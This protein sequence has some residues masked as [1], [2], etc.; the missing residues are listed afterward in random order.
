MDSNDVLDDKDSG[1]EVQLNFPASVMSRIEE[2]MGG[3]E[4]FDM[5]YINRVFPT[6]Q[7]LSAVEA[8]AAR[9]EFRLAAVQHDMQRLVRAQHDQRVADINK[10][11]SRSESMVREITSEIK[12]LDCAKWNL[13]S[14]ITA[15][16]HLHML[17]GGAATLRSL[18]QNRQY[19]ELVLPLQAIMEVLQHL[20]CYRDIRELN[21]LRE[22]VRVIRSQ[23]ADQIVADFKQAFTGECHSLYHTI[24]EYEH[25]FS[26]EQ[27]SAWLAHIERRY[28]WLKKHLLSFEETLGAVFP[29]HWRLSERIAYQFCK[30][31]RDMLSE[32]LVSRRGEVDV[33]LLLYRDSGGDIGHPRDRIMSYGVVPWQEARSLEVGAGGEG[34]A[35]GG[36]GV[37]SS[38]AELFVVYKKCLA[39]CAA[40]STA[41]PMLDP[42]IILRLASPR[43][44]ETVLASYFNFNKHNPSDKLNSSHLG[45]GGDKEPIYL[46]EHL[47]P[48]NRELHAQARIF[49]KENQYKYVWVRNGRVMLRKDDSTSAVWVKNTEILWNIKCASIV[50]FSMQRCNTNS[51]KSDGGGVLVV[52]RKELEYTRLF[53]YECTI[54]DLWIKIKSEMPDKNIFNSL[55]NCD[56]YLPPPLTIAI[57]LID[58]SDALVADDFNTAQI[59]WNIIPNQIDAYTSTTP[60][61]TSKNGEINIIILY[62][63]FYI[64]MLSNHLKTENLVNVSTQIFKVVSCPLKESDIVGISRVRKIDPNNTRPRSIV[65]KLSSTKHRDIV[66]AAVANYN[67]NNKENKLNS[68]SIGYGGPVSAIYISEHLSPYYNKL[69]SQTR[70]LALRTDTNSRFINICGVYLPP[71]LTLPQLDNF[72]DSVSNV[73]NSSNNKTIVVGDFNLSFLKWSMST[74]S[75]TYPQL[76]PSNYDSNIG[77]SFVDFLSENNLMQINRIKNFNDRIL[78]LILCNFKGGKVSYPEEPLSKIDIHHPPLLINFDIVCHSNLKAVPFATYSFRKA[79]YDY[80]ITQLDKVDWQTELENCDNT[81]TM[82][83]KFYKSIQ[84]I[85][86]KTVPNYN[87]N[88]S[89]CILLDINILYNLFLVVLLD[90]FIS[91]YFSETIVFID[92]SDVI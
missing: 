15:L 62:W 22:D 53:C 31:T 34:V 69:H 16:N 73:L 20:E 23:L 52:I 88:F 5:A 28:A 9:C 66:I 46:M 86:E 57:T 75:E 81:N 83:D 67:K 59:S 80:V 39:Q 32:V 19:K 13:T 43:A 33:K 89:D 21:V 87:C 3:T 79:D 4:Q 72:L 50:I 49:K 92:I 48:S 12:Q 18:A 17:A 10:K 29:P 56:V 78:D 26:R 74:D 84:N 27:E 41:E 2:L 30:V 36:G 42:S 45:I 11:A 65:L 61:C 63:V 47:S 44:R 51:A 1:P 40:L 58:N 14:A 64:R 24:S 25:L 77:Y 55:C 7:S 91:I 37:L 90:I 82:V 70:R 60:N 71:P 68:K 76:I 35:S 8:A 38:C 6:E 54:E 85:I